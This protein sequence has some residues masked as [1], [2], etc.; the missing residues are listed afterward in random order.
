MNVSKRSKW[1]HQGSCEEAHLGDHGRWRW[2]CLEDLSRRN[3][4]IREGVFKLTATVQAC[5]LGTLRWQQGKRSRL[6]ELHSRD[7]D[8][9]SAEDGLNVYS[10]HPNVMWQS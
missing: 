7:Q 5:K 1:T 9:S 8:D 10:R 4:G 3:K 6:M 2:L